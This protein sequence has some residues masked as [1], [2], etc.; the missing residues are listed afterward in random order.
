MSRPLPRSEILVSQALRD[1]WLA[2]IG[3]GSVSDACRHMGLNGSPK[4]TSEGNIPD[5]WRCRIERQ[6]A[7]APSLEGL[8]DQSGVDRGAA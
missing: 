5:Q 3:H 4:W 7:K 6:M 2:W 1:R 8:L